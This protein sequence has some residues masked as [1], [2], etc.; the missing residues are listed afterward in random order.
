MKLNMLAVSVMALIMASCGK[1]QQQTPSAVYK[2][3]KVEKEDVT[4]ESKYSATIRGRQDVN[5][6]PQVAGTIHQICVTEGQHVSAGQTLFIIDQVPYEAALRTAEAA[7]EAAKVYELFGKDALYPGAKVDEVPA[8]DHP[9][10]STLGY[11]IHEGGHGVMPQ[12]W[13]YYLEFIKKH[14]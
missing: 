13:T 5:I 11:V 3:M 12:D 1:Q 14:L 7:L 6:L 10:Y 8:A 9:V 4:I 2:T